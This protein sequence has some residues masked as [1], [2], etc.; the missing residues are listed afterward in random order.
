LH[1]HI[2]FGN[3]ARSLFVLLASALLKALLH[4]LTLLRDVLAT[5]CSALGFG[6]LE[7]PSHYSVL[8]STV[9]ASCKVRHSCC[10]AYILNR[11]YARARQTLERSPL[12]YHHGFMLSRIA[13]AYL[14]ECTDAVVEYCSTRNGLYGR[15]YLPGRT[16]MST[17]RF[18]PAT[19]PSAHTDSRGVRALPAN[20]ISVP[21]TTLFLRLLSSLFLLICL[22]VPSRAHA[23]ITV[24]SVVVTP[25]TVAA[26]GTVQ[27]T[28]VLSA[29]VAVNTTVM[30][31][32]GDT[33]KVTVPATVTVN[34]GSAAANFTITAVST[35]ATPGAVNITAFYNGSSQF[36]VVTVITV[37]SVTVLPTS[38]FAGSTSQ[39]TVTLSAP[40]AVGTIVTLS[41]SD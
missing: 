27:G 14:R 20:P 35:N 5:F 36:G 37:Q 19:Y 8:L 34:A 32:S 1:F 29:S 2:P 24:A 41:S 31:S 21:Q 30:L 22:L 10:S 4:L 16:L 39:G 28:V 11:F 7:V 38:I 15:N 18:L 17:D 9:V 12:R 40:V 6:L 33:N 13:K 25:N 26:G 23:V 3:A